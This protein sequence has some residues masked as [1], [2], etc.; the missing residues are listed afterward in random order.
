MV[1]EASP[2]T[3]LPRL[4]PKLARYV[5]RPENLTWSELINAAGE[6]LR[7]DLGV[8][9]PSGARLALP[10]AGNRP[11]SHWDNVSIHAGGGVSGSARRVGLRCS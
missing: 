5:H 6:W 9:N 2:W 7:Q 8:S 3:K 1:H 4:A 10:W 11:R